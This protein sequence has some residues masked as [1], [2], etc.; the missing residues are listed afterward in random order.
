MN[1]KEEKISDAEAIVAGSIIIIS[2]VS[3]FIFIVLS[4]PEIP[5]INF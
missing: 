3:F 5:T 1:D 4:I 2:L